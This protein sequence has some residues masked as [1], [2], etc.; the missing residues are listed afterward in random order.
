MKDKAFFESKNDWYLIECKRIIHSAY[1]KLC[2]FECIYSNG[3]FE[4]KCI[5]YFNKDIPTIID[6]ERM[7]RINSNDNN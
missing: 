7:Q 6:Y 4:I 1:N 2:C 5:Q 3:V